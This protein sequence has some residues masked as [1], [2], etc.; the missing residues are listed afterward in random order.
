MNIRSGEMGES[1]FL[2]VSFYFIFEDHLE[3]YLG[4]TNENIQ[5]RLNPVR[6]TDF[7]CDRFDSVD[8]GE[9]LKTQ[10]GDCALL[11]NTWNFDYG[12][13]SDGREW[14][15]KFRT[16]VFQKRCVGNAVKS[17]GAP[18]AGCSGSG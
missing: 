8:H 2:T 15:A 12:L 4:M 14:T 16:G 10:L 13:G 11:P 3:W 7:Y 18:N 6:S 5:T 1:I 17:A 9:G